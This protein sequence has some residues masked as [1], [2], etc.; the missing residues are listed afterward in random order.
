MQQLSEVSEAASPLAA[1]TSSGRRLP[2][3]ASGGALSLSEPVLQPHPFFQAHRRVRCAL[4][5]GE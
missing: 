1:V 4:H 5:H 2:H 3:S